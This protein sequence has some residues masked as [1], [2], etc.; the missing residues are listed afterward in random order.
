ML[1]G[2]PI[3]ADAPLGYAHARYAESFAEFGVPR[4][5]PR[6]GGWL[7]E[8]AIPG[9]S[10]RDAMGCYPLFACRDWSRLHEDLAELAGGIVSLTLVP[11]PLG[12]MAPEEL[13]R[14]FGDGVIPFKEHCV[15]DLH[16]SREAS[17]SAHHCR[18]AKKALKALSVEE[19]AQPESF[20]DEWMPLFAT[21]AEKHHLHG[22]RA[23]SRE[24]FAKQLSTPGM[25]VLHARLGGETVGAA[26][27]FV[28][29]QQ[30]AV[31]GHV[32]GYTPAGYALGVQY[33]LY[34]AGWERFAPQVRWCWV[35]GVPG[36]SDGEQGGLA[37][38]KRG[39]SRVTRPAYLCRRIF[40]RDRYDAITAQTGTTGRSYF[41]AYRDGELA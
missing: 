10:D 11:D 29:E 1:T 33:A 38:F 39:W 13:R 27:W 40:D 9:F 15:I 14:C 21:V 37:W 8:R 36:R 35:G 2:V 3:R 23:F 16:R 26:L 28:C 4:G 25:V 30:N 32:L 6:S 12:I 34:W 18:Y 22:L 17:V 20:L 41:P 19:C 7:L 5:L 31:Y 24:A